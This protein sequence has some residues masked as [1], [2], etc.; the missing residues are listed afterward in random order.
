MRRSQGLLPNS[1]RLVIEHVRGL[2]GGD[3]YLADGALD[4]FRSETDKDKYLFYRV[5]AASTHSPKDATETTAS[6][7]NRTLGAARLGQKTN[8]LCISITVK[9]R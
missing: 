8:I 1:V 3:K 9:L 6:A 5:D 2:T 4:S 7:L